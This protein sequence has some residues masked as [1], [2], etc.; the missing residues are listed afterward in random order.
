MFDDDLN[1]SGPREV[2]AG[3]PRPQLVREHWSDLCGQWSFQHD[4]SDIGLEERWF[5]RESLAGT[6]VVPFP[7]ESA[8]SG[9]GET[10]HHR[11]VWY[12]RGF[13]A[14]EL[15][16][17]G[18]REGSRILLHFGAVDY[19]SR[20]W[21]DGSFVGAH[22]GG[23]TPFAIDI[24]EAL[25][26]RETHSIVVRVEDDPED[27]E[28]PRG[29]QDW[30]EHPHVIWYHRTSGIWQ[31]VWLEA[32]EPVSVRS[33]HWVTDVHAATVSA[34]LDLSRVPAEPVAV[35]IR[36]AFGGKVLGEVTTSTDRASVTVSLPVPLLGNGQGYE[37][38]LWSPEHP[39]LVDADV[40]VGDD[41]VQ[42]YLGLRTVHVGQNAFWLNDRPYYLRSVLNQGYWPESHLA[43]PS[44]DA[45]R[46]EA[47]LIKDLGFNATRV[48]QKF[49]DPRFLYWAD[50]LGILVWGEAPAA[51]EYS[52]TAVERM[53]REW[54]DIVRRDFSHPSIVAWVPLNESWGVQHI[55]SDARMQHYARSLV[56]LTKALDPTRPVV[57]NDGWE[58]VDTD[59]VAIHDYEADPDIMRERY[60]D[61]AAVDRM[62]RTAGPAGRR[63]ILSGDVDDKPVMLT[64]FGGISYDVDAHDHAWGY[65]T[66]SSGDDFAERLEGLMGAVHDSRALQGFC[67]T[68]LTDTLQETNG[69]LTEAREPKIPIERIRRAITGR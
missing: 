37:Q 8:A 36:L 20:I 63:L 39:R 46:A 13:G 10:A 57:S 24:T 43:A 55:A 66:A 22:E 56:D 2:P 27:V 29:K 58:Q 38:L 42:S 47:Q 7:P 34:R 64:E 19:R 12:Q 52:T 61:R 59:I 15:E 40:R 65:S 67:Y 53:V 62:I 28:Q 33:V 32:V 11:V 16:A 21:I 68:Q 49:E 14:A 18:R 9:V 30:L 4:D 23:H 54:L 44:A 41:A 45:L 35:S 3:Y 69:L 31:P 1:R 26:E 48:H 50:R 17:A 60:A 6:I 51:F 25:H 5:E